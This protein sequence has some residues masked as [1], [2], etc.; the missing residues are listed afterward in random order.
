MCTAASTGGIASSQQHKEGKTMKSCKASESAPQPAM[1]LHGSIEDASILWLWQ[2]L[3]IIRTSLRDH[4]C[5]RQPHMKGVRPG[6]EH[7]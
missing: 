2:G 5:S 3:Y 4:Q 6:K 7:A 1:Q